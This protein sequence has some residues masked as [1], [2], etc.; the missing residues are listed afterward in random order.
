MLVILMTKLWTSRLKA[1]Q[2]LNINRSL[3]RSR[4][5]VAS[6]YL[7]IVQS[8]LLHLLEHFVQH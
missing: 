4:F 6:D 1:L 3:D 5:N 7:Y 2:F 8:E